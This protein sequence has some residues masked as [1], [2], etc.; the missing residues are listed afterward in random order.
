MVDKTLETSIAT[1]D[2]AATDIS[3][4]SLGDLAQ[5]N[6]PLN[7]LVSKLGEDGVEMIFNAITQ[8][9]EELGQELERKNYVYGDLTAKEIDLNAWQTAADVVKHFDSVELVKKHPKTAKD[10]LVTVLMM[11]PPTV[12]PAMLCKRIPEDKLTNILGF[13]LQ[14]SPDHLVNMLVTHKANVVRNRQLGFSKEDY[15]ERGKRNLVLVTKD[16]LLYHQ[17]KELVELSDDEDDEIVIGT[18]DGTVRLTRWDEQKWVYRN[19]TETVNTKVIVIGDCKD[20][21]TGADMMTVVYDQ[22]GIRYGWNGN[23][24]FVL[25]DL[26]RIHSKGIY[27][28]F[29]K[30]LREMPAPKAIKE[31]KKLRLNWKTGLKTM[32]ATPL[33]AKDLY[34]DNYAVKRQMYFFGIIHFYYHHMEEFLNE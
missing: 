26:R 34:D 7:T 29:L 32:L 10:T 21:N 6:D 8:E 24:A 33:M 9:A 18:K 22:Y 12:I 15:S 5:T 30:E 11:F 14:A 28:V 4:T 1:T 23:C 3:E 25:A 13:S 19:K 20:A 2:V 31:D 27:D 17:L 16:E